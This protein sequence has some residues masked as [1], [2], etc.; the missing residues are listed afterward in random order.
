MSEKRKINRFEGTPL[1]ISIYSADRIPTQLHDENMLEII[2]CLKGEITLSY[3]YED[4]PIRAGEFVSVDKD[5]YYLCDGEDNICISFYIY[6]NSF[7]AKYPFLPAALFVCEGIGSNLEKPDF[8]QLKGTLVSLLK[9]LT[10]T[11][12]PDARRIN[13]ITERIVRMFISR[14]DILFYWYTNPDDV[15]DELMDR[16]HKINSYMY[17]HFTERITVKDLA[18]EL[19]LTTGYVSEYMRKISVG[20]RNMLSYRRANMS[21]PLLLGTGRTVMQISEECGFSD[22]KYFYSAFKKWYNCTPA[23]FRKKYGDNSAGDSRILYYSLDDI[24]DELDRSLVSHYLKMF[25][26]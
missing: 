24:K 11:E 13:E 17:E 2:F 25:L 26:Q 4:I 5:A 19:N 14:F 10:D 22:V 20:F 18:H 9:Y 6:L 21:E 12:E 1:G 15:T 7:E 3:G 8:R 23:Q 16:Y